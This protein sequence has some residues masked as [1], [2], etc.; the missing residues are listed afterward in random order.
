MPRDEGEP[1]KILFVI[2]LLAG[3]GAA[4][5]PGPPLAKLPCQ[6]VRFDPMRL[7]YFQS[8]GVPFNGSCLGTR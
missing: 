6:V 4:M 1:M 7:A 2:T 8:L 5:L 3:C